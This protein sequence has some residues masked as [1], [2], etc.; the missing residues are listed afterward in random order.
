MYAIR[1]Y[2]EH[3]GDH[4]GEGGGEKLVAFTALVG[5]GELGLGKKG[6]EDPRFADAGLMRGE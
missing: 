2:Y 3:G 5:G 4:E 1:S 6:K